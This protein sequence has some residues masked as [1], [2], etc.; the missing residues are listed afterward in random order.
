MAKAK[1]S[2]NKISQA[3][4]PPTDTP[5]RRGSYVPPATPVRPS[6]EALSQVEV[7]FLESGFLQAVY[8]CNEAIRKGWSPKAEQWWSEVWRPE[9]GKA[10]TKCKQTGMPADRLGEFRRLIKELDKKWKLTCELRDGISLVGPVAIEPAEAGQ[11]EGRQIT[12]VKGVLQELYP[13]GADG[14][15]TTTIKAAV[16]VEFEKRDWQA[17]GYDTVARAL[18]RRK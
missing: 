14:I 3:P 18:G 15:S 1:N 6:W 4:P 5:L 11:R 2:S 7:G 9:L 16:Q 17:A 13:S 8:R 12:R 10:F